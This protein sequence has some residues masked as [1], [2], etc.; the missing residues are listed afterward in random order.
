MPDTSTSKGTSTSE[1]Q[2]GALT[3][4][5]GAF[6]AFKDIKIEPVIAVLI[7]TITIVYII[8]R[9]VVKQAQIKAAVKPD[10]NG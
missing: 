1:F 2:F 7:G 10:V 9:T 4:V 8:S 3:S 5:L 6:V